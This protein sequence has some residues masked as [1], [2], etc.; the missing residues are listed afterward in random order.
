MISLRIKLQHKFTYL[1][2][3]VQIQSTQDYKHKYNFR[4][5]QYMLHSDDKYER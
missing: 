1:N 4:L 3:S 2:T 5:Y